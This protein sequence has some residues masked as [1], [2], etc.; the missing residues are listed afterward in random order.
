MVSLLGAIGGILLVDLVLSG[1]NALV[2][3][4]AAASLPRQQRWR[5]IMLGGGAAIVLR[6]L[7]ASLAAL[8]LTLPFLQAIGGVLLLLI[9]AR[10]L[11]GRSEGPAE[12]VANSAVEETAEGASTP[13]AS[14]SFLGAL[15]TI[16]VADVTMSL[17][18]ILAI[19]ALSHGNIPLLVAGLTLS[20]ALL[21][22]GSALVA[23]LIGR[24]PWLLDVA[25]LVL[26]WTAANMLLHDRQIGP[27][28]HGL[29]GAEVGVHVLCVGLVL[30]VDVALRRRTTRQTTIAQVAAARPDETVTPPHATTRLD[31]ASVVTPAS[32][33]T[34]APYLMSRKP[35]APRSQSPSTR[36]ATDD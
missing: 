29:P 8:L 27:L 24:L 28:L 12:T 7:F 35:A 20:I 19:G 30:A 1:D 32:P 9:A 21:L 31:D 36:A 5:A 22:L 14:K 18:N 34:S 2:I 25:A 11:A 6:V 4:A 33:L 3:G 16:L 17:D 10:L 13:R 15:L 23:E 26:G